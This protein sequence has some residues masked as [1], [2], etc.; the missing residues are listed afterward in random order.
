MDPFLAVKQE[1]EQNLIKAAELVKK[2]ANSGA[3]FKTL[4]SSITEDLNDLEEALNAAK[5]NPSKFNL[6]SFDISNRSDFISKSRATLSQLRASTK[7]QEQERNVFL[8]NTGVIRKV[9]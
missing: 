5:N 7:N 1:V 8:I 4:I 6:S 3:V 2:Q 9:F